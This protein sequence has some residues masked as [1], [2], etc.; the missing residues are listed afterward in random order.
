[1]GLTG[2]RR[3]SSKD[4]KKPEGYSRPLARRILEELQSSSCNFNLQT[5][6]ILQHNTTVGSNGFAH[7][8]A[9]GFVVGLSNLLS[10][11]SSPAH[12]LPR[13]GQRRL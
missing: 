5:L 8:I 11:S 7:P 6:C 13:C 10:E 2:K 4:P 12:F 9:W 1:M 3:R